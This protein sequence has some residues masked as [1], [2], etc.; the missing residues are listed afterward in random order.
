MCFF[1][2]DIVGYD[3]GLNRL[4]YISPLE[5]CCYYYCW[6]EDKITDRWDSCNYDAVLKLEGKLWTKVWKNYDAD[7]NLGRGSKLFKVL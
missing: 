4:K 6:K 2:D 5:D 3:K 7:I 1:S